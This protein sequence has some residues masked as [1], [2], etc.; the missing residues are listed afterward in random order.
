MR[1][2]R[3]FIFFI[4]VGIVYFVAA[5]SNAS[6]T[7]DRKRAHFAS[8]RLDPDTGHDDAATPDSGDAGLQPD[9]GPYTN[10][11]AVE[12]NDGGTTGE[13]ITCPDLPALGS[14]TRVVWSFWIK[15]HVQ[16]GVVD[17]D[18]MSQ[19]PLVAGQDGWVIREVTNRKIRVFISG[20]GLVDAF[21]TGTPGV[22]N[23]TW[24]HVCVDFDGSGSGNGGRLNVYLDGTATSMAYSGT[25][26]ALVFNSNRTVVIGNIYASGTT[27]L[28]AY[29]DEVN[30][31]TGGSPPTCAAIYDGRHLRYFADF[32]PRPTY[33]WDFNGDT[34]STIHD[35]TDGGADCTST[36][37][38]AND[39]V[40]GT[41]A[42]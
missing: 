4:A 22:T 8:T 25:I 39:F 3:L 6:L 27:P 5:D 37:M 7:R 26:P 29:L 31:W 10:T 34:V 9:A 28:S 1:W 21:G 36:A 15:N 13:Y 14:A 20:D 24:T 41:V 35:K 30:I 16:D 11:T 33:S 2:F 19:Y 18:I 40:T 42:P 32:S 12:I 17:E 38:T 23:N